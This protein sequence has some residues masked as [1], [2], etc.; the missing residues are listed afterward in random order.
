MPY[1][2]NLYSADD[3]DIESF[4][5]ELSPTDGY[6]TGP[7]PSN[8]M[9][10]DPSLEQTSSAESKAQEARAEAES[11]PENHSS[12][13]PLQ[14]QSPFPPLNHFQ[15][16]ASASYSGYPAVTAA[17][18][19]SSTSPTTPVSPF[20]RV[21]DTQPR[22]NFYSEDSP[23]LRPFAPP[24][25]YSAAT[26]ASQSSHP[27]QSF[28]RNYNTIS[29]GDLEHGQIQ[30]RMPESMGGPVDS[31]E[32]QPLWSRDRDSGSRLPRARRWLIILLALGLAAVALVTSFIPGSSVSV[33]SHKTSVISRSPNTCSNQIA[34]TQFW[35][36]STYKQC[37]P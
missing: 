4:S 5:D 10:P 13:T 23:L 28:G 32:R 27:S 36:L 25:T 20:R 8:A 17:S 11:N 9:V 3:S 1:A 19:N 21:P 15:P 31:N 7:S 29:E 14:T 2:D 35:R 34:F 16:S 12:P 37:F 30:T 22:H 6:F 18:S 33:Y 24:P 26:S